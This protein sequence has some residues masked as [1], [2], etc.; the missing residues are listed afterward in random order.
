MKPKKV[1]YSIHKGST[2]AYVFNE[3]NPGHIK[4]F[5]LSKIHL[6]IY[7]YLRIFLPSGFTPSVYPTS[8][9]FLSALFILHNHPKWMP[10]TWLL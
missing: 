10:V 1:R 6:I 7:I 2:I 9:M 8:N 4:P 3:T 5:Y